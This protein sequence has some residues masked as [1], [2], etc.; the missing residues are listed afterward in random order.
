MQSGQV[1][2]WYDKV[3]EF[4]SE[5]CI[6]ASDAFAKLTLQVMGIE[7]KPI[8][9]AHGYAPTNLKH[10]Y[11]KFEISDHAFEK[12]REYAKRNPSL[13]ITD[14]STK[15][16][17]GSGN[18]KQIRMNGHAMLDQILPSIKRYL[19]WN[20]GVA[21][22]YRKPYIL[23]LEKEK[24][25][26]IK[27]I[28][29]NNETMQ[30]LLLSSRAVA[31]LTKESKRLKAHLNAIESKIENAKKLTSF[32]IGRSISDEIQLTEHFL[33]KIK[34][35][36]SEG[37]KQDAKAHYQ[38]LMV[39]P[40]QQTQPFKAY[41]QEL[42][43]LKKLLDRAPRRLDSLKE[44]LNSNLRDSEKNEKSMQPLQEQFSRVKAAWVSFPGDYWELRP[45]L[46]E[47]EALIKLKLQ[48][49]KNQHT[50]SS[51]GL[52]ST[53]TKSIAVTGTAL[54]VAAVVVGVISRTM[55]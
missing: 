49:W 53:K 34:T 32:Y 50:A 3:N 54:G 42:T 11:F 44:Q 30:G 9:C 29:T 55:K 20:S 10:C 33:Q 18:V 6:T 41:L 23:Q 13:E 19:F 43:S 52:F 8:S 21:A 12:L 47:V 48:K 36:P 14:E 37:L 16:P 39:D 22:A 28:F 35:N 5:Q 45:K 25:A 24:F 40:F 7:E 38:H 26:C 4:I 17:S 15:M 51:S 27:A 1:E 46:A 31:N 2:N